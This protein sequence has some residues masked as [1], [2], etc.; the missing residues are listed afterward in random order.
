MGIVAGRGRGLGR[1]LQQGDLVDV[2]GG[3]WVRKVLPPGDGEGVLGQCL[4]WGVRGLCQV[5]GADRGG[6]RRAVLAGLLPVGGD[7][8]GMARAAR[9]FPRRLHFRERGCGTGVQ[10]LPRGGQQLGVRR[11]LDQRM[12]EPVSILAGFQQPVTDR[13]GQPI[14][15]VRGLG[16]RGE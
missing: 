6:Q 2:G 16:H 4:G 15:Q 10:R 9:G 8:H 13:R 3:L 5:T 14:V 7:L 11:L 12:P 1:S